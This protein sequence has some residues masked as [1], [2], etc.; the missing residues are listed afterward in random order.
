MKGIDQEELDTGLLRSEGWAA[1]GGGWT[2]AIYG[3]ASRTGALLI[4]SANGQAYARGRDDE[5]DLWEGLED[6][7]CLRACCSH[8]SGGQC[9]LYLYQKIQ[10]I[11]E[12]RHDDDE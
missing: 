9:L 4:I 6:T 1:V 11:K 8:V 7:L 2:H 3:T 12:A 10:A 5:F